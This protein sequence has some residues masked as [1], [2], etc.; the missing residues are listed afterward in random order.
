ML[1]SRESLN[2]TALRNDDATEP[3]PNLRSKER[4]Q[5]LARAT[6]GGWVIASPF[7][8]GE[9][10]SSTQIFSG[11]NAVRNCRPGCASR[12]MEGNLFVALFLPV[13]SARAQK[14]SHLI[15]ECIPPVRIFRFEFPR[16]IEDASLPL[17]GFISNIASW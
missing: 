16:G 11:T 9:R 17:I 12:L 4:R 7:G 10:V 13:V 8:A 6:T 14:L 1:T 2:E 15:E 5:L 3:N